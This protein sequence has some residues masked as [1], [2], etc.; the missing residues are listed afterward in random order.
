MKTFGELFI[1][2]QFRCTQI[3]YLLL[4]EFVVVFR[5]CNLCLGGC[6]TECYLDREVSDLSIYYASDVLKIT[7]YR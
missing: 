6:I 5:T 2:P 3:K 4:L 1:F 7:A